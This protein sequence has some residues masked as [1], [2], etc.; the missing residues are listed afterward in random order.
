MKRILFTL[1]AAL[2]VLPASVHA[3]D[4]APAPANV[5]QELIAAKGQSIVSVKMVIALSGSF[6]GQS[7]D[8]EI[9]STATGIVVDAS[10]LV[11]LSSENFSPQLPRRMRAMLTDLKVV[12]TNI[13]VIFPGDEVEYDA[14]LGAK[15]TK[16]GLGFVFIKDLKGRSAAPVDLSKTVTPIVGQ[17][18]YGVTRLAQ[19][20]DHAS[21]CDTATVVGSLTKPRKV[22]LLSR[23]ASFNALPLYDASGAAAGVVV[24]QEGVTDDA[25][26]RV[27]L[28]PLGVAKSTIG[29]SL[30]AAQDALADALEAE[31]EAA[32][33]AAEEAAAAEAEKDDAEKAEGDAKKEEGDAKKDEPKADEPK[34]DDSGK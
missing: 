4:T 7:I 29:R 31:A 17:T 28:L 13:R 33:V 26:S 8:R 32:A 21:M 25:G 27:C 6:Q 18:L 23:A 10:G 2:L 15:D 16:L 1:A 22:W 24:N 34:K 30:K 9:K 5:H 14:I 11:M 19:G 20:F 12:P 3:E